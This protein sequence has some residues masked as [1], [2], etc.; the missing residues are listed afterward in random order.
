MSAN[1]QSPS[2]VAAPPPSVRTARALLLVSVGFGLLSL[3]LTIAFKDDLIDRYLED[4]SDGVRADELVPS[5]V[6]IAVI[7]FVVFGAL[8]LLLISFLTKGAN[9]ARIVV[10]LLGALNVLGT[11]LSLGQDQ[12]F[13]FSLIGLVQTALLVAAIAFLYRRDSNE[14]YRWR[15]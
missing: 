7:S 8:M 13:A 12:P 15:G 14:Y 3:I 9:W 4:R 11:L 6:P 1:P 10:T 2:G 5:F